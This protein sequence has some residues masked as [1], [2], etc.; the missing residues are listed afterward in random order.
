MENTLSSRDRVRQRSEFLRIQEQ[1]GRVR[2]RHLTLFVLPNDFEV[3]RLGII[4]TRRLGGAIRRNRSKRMIREMFRRNK[5][6]Y[7]GFAL[8]IVVLPRPGFSDKTFNVLQT[9]YLNTLRRYARSK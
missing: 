6:E 4:A 9:D 1:G 8:D 2:G 5:S 3:T 7:E